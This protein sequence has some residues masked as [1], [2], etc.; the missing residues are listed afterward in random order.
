MWF[1]L[2]SAIIFAVVASNLHWHWTENGY[3]AGL[4]GAVLAYGVAVLLSYITS[5]LKI[6]RTSDSR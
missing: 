2:Q 3:L 6:K 5:L 4:I 1:L